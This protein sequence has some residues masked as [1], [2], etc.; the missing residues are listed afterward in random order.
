MS[1]IGLLTAYGLAII[2][3]T[4]PHLKKYGGFNEMMKW[5]T[6]T[7]AEKCDFKK[8]LTSEER[9]KKIEVYDDGKTT[10]FALTGV[11]S[12]SDW[13]VELIADVDDDGINKWL[14]DENNCVN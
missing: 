11:K 5:S 2:P 6:L 9:S 3:R 13:E 14:K 1:Y 8:F 4:L 12:G 7:P 10:V